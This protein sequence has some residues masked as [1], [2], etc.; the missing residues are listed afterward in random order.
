MIFFFI[1]NFCFIPSTIAKS[2]II[3]ET[4]KFTR[5]RVVATHIAFLLIRKVGNV[6]FYPF[7]MVNAQN[8]LK[9]DAASKMG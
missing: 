4:N 1:F 9:F 5:E 7:C 8:R 6:F 3:I 2:F